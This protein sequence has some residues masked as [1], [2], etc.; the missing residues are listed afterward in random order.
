MEEQ[1]AYQT[2]SFVSAWFQSGQHNQGL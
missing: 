2:L 1:I